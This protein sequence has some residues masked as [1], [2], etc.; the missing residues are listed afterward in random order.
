V[1]VTATSS[2]TVSDERRSHRRLLFDLIEEH[3]LAPVA[4]ESG[5]R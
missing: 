5:A 2:T 4:A 1:V 3:V